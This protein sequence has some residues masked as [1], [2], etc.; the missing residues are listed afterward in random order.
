MKHKCKI[1]YPF[2]VATSF[3]RKNI[4]AGLIA[5]DSALPALEGGVYYNASE[6]PDADGSKTYIAAQGPIVQA[7]A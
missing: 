3:P 1:R 5:P 2:Q 7:T 6:V 4:A